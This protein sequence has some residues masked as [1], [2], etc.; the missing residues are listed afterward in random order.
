[1]RYITLIAAIAVCV[2]LSGCDVVAPNISKAK[3]EKQQL[4]EIK[5]QNEYYE[6]IAN[7]LEKMANK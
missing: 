1:M 4:K 3:T 5:T 7:A 6:R 2:M